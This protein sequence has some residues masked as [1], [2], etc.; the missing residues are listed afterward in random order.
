ML[1]LCQNET[2]ITMNQ[3]KNPSELIKQT[4]CCV[5]LLLA[6]L[7]YVSI[8]NNRSLCNYLGGCRLCAQRHT[9]VTL[10]FRLGCNEPA[11]CHCANFHS[12]HLRGVGRSSTTGVEPETFNTEPKIFTSHFCYTSS[13]RSS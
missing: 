9:S 12:S 13:H 5:C 3:K 4:C 6:S 1:L 8:K 2:Q 10:D 7:P 11:G